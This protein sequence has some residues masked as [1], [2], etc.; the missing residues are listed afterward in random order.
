MCERSVGSLKNLLGP[1]CILAEVPAGRL[2][3]KSRIRMAQNIVGHEGPARVAWGQL[4]DSL[5]KEGILISVQLP[6]HGG[7]GL[8]RA[9]RLAEH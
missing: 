8:P 2:V 4:V 7:I 6:D 1:D 3:F 9:H 5:I